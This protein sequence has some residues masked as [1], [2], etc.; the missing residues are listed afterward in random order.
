MRILTSP[1]IK[2][3]V[4]ELKILVGSFVN[5]IYQ[6]SRTHILFKMRKEGNDYYLKNIVGKALFLTQYKKRLDSPPPHFPAS[7]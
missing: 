7:G 3:L 6:P 2:I 4:E 5:K 1:E